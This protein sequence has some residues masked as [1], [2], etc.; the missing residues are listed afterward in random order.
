VEIRTKLAT[1]IP[2]LVAL[3]YVFYTT[4]TINLISSFIYILA[5]LFLDMA[6]TAINNHL[7][8]RE[9][10]KEPH[11]SFRKSLTIIIVMLTISAGIGLYLV[12][13]HGLAI[14]LAGMFCF[15]I[16]ITYT[17]GPAPIS[18]SCYGELLSGFVVGTVVMFIVVSINDPA[19]QP[20]GLALNFQEMR[21]VLDIDLM[22]IFSF[23]IITLP[24][25]FGGAN[26]MLANNICDEE[27]D[28]ALRYTL[29]HNIGR[30]NALYLF[31]CLYYGTYLSIVVSS[32]LGWI[33]IWCIFTLVTLFPV[34]KNINR[35]FKKQTKH[36]T[37]A[38]SVNNYVLILLSL[39]ASMLV[40]YFI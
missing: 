5:A 21:L 29:V 15:L 16:G 19:F 23:V 40:G 36:E 1:F 37:F 6:V 20:L 2:F 24:A 33:P 38:L 4:G 14:L 12:Y 3:A 8:K 13:L 9:E 31:A 35:F 28:R 25:A 17:F 30:K 39:A 22:R 18:K 34:Q 7:N 26:I 32:R 11:Y 10:N 27:E